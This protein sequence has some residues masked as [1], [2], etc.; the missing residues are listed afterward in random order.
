M[1]VAILGIVSLLA[2]ERG[3]D[4]SGHSSFIVNVLGAALIDVGLIAY[5]ESTASM[6]R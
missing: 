6:Q 5:V 3:E 1:N 2:D 4:L